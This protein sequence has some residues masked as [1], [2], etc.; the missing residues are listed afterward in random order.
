M[1]II[2]YLLVRW[3]KHLLQL[4]LDCSEWTTDYQCR[5]IMGENYQR[6]NAFFPKRIELLD[7]KQIPS[8]LKVADQVDIQPTVEWLRANGWGNSSSYN[9]NTSD[10]EA[11]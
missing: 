7:I 10:I 5:Q 3:G 2:D 6:V 8:L 9:I 1:I 4:L 11:L